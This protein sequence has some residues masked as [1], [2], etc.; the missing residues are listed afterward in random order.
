M[1]AIEGLLE[2]LAVQLG[3]V[4]I[5]IAIPSGDGAE[6]CGFFHRAAHRFFPIGK[7]FAEA[8]AFGAEDLFI[9]GN[10]VGD[11]AG[12]LF[13]FREG[14]VDG[15][16][17]RDA[18]FHGAFGGDAMDSG[19]FGGD[20]E[21]IG[22]DDAR[23]A[24]T[25]VSGFVA[26]HPGELD[27]ARP[28]AE[29]GDR[30]LPVFREAGG[31]GVEKEQA[32]VGRPV[33]VEY[34]FIH[35]EQ[36][37]AGA[38][39]LQSRIGMKYGLVRAI[40][41]GYA[42]RVKMDRNQTETPSSAEP[43]PRVLF[44]ASE[45]APF[46]KCGGLGDVVASL[47]KALRRL[48][49]DAR[50]VIPLYDSIDREFHALHAEPSCLVR[51]GGN[52]VNGCGVW[53]GTADGEVPMWFIEHNRFF[54]RG[55]IYDHEGVAFDDQAFRF[56][57]LCMAAAQVCRDREWIPDVVHVHDWPT[58]ILPVLM[59]AWR[60]AGNPLGHAGSV[61]TIHNQGYQ[62]YSHVS[63]LDYLGLG[64]EVFTA[65][66]LESYG[67]INLLKGGIVFADAITTVSPTYAKEILTEPGGQ[68]LSAILQRRA[69]DFEG[70]L[71]GADYGVWNPEEDRAIPATYRS[72]SLIGKGLCKQE[73]QSQMGLGAD[74]ALPLFGMV[75][76]L[77]AQKGIGLMREVLPPA[78]EQMEMQL[79]VLGAGEPADEDFFRELAGRFP[80]RV[81]VE[82]G[83][84]DEL[85]HRIQ[86]GADFFLMPSLFE[87]CGL[88]Q[89][90]ALRYGTLPVVHA[91]GGLEDT[92]EQYNEGEGTGT[93]FKFYSPDAA[94]FRDALGWAVATWHDRPS[95]ITRMRELAMTRRFDWATSAKR[96]RE[97]YRR[98]VARQTGS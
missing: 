8:Q 45:C 58:A 7:G 74:P 2:E 84:S 34:H 35:G 80:G 12:G 97:I 52:E 78:L 94:A 51:A 91:T 70:I 28:V 93:G 53:A 16:G 20:V 71:N 79:V 65:D 3:Q 13:D 26:E 21:P 42:G 88:S 87:P 24:G 15:V 33:E 69:A 50:V 64:P 43:V 23:G 36:Y 41:E 48:G 73:L 95:H 98:V 46:A 92:V 49:V 83:Y 30:G 19:G 29:I 22:A 38:G 61:L 85:S 11:E 5:L 75:S 4:G 60:K 9:E 56:G 37:M 47:P 81:G 1:R 31:F 59:E 96:Y 27:H 57:L 54:A 68:G 86:A 18:F 39:V 55:G 40:G 76:R 72:T 6:V 32:G 17:Q 62:G 77:T 14:F 89:L 25:F 63:A 67:K 82:I 66:T 44:V 90:Y 10:V